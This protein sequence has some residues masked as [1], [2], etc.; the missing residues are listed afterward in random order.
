VAELIT[1]VALNLHLVRRLALLC[2]AALGY[3]TKLFTVATFRDAT[4]DGNAG[5]SKALKILLSRGRPAI[6]LLGTLRARAVAEGDRVLL[7]KVALE[8][9]VAIG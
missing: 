2:R 8:I 9:H 5:I 1:V 6:T 3:V 4:I 7:V